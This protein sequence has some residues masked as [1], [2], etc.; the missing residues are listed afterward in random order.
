M[1]MTRFTDA[2]REAF[3]FGLRLAIGV[4]LLFWVLL[5]IGCTSCW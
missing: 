2:P 4:V 3:R 5:G 1:R